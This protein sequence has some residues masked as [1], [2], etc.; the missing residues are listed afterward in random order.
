[1]IRVQGM[2]DQDEDDPIVWERYEDQVTPDGLRWRH[3]YLRQ[4]VRDNLIKY[5][6][7]DGLRD[8]LEDSEKRWKMRGVN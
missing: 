6:G 2:T 5:L 1:M 8:Y 4:S 7:E 3:I